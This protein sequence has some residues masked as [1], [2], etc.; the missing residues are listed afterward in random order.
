[1]AP[2][3]EAEGLVIR[4]KQMAAVGAEF[5]LLLFAIARDG[6]GEI[7]FRAPFFF[8][9]GLVETDE[10]AVVGAVAV[11]AVE[12]AV[13]VEGGHEMGGEFVVFPELFEVEFFVLA[14]GELEQRAAFAV[15]FGDVDFVID[16][17]GGGGI[18]GSG[19]FA[20]PR[21]GEVDRGISGIDAKETAGC[22]A[23]FAAC[24]DEDAAL[25]LDGGG[26]W[27]GVRG[28]PVFG[29]GSGASGFAG[30]DI[31]GHDT[32]VLC[33]DVDD[34]VVLFQ[35]GRGTYSEEIGGEI[36]IFEDVAFPEELSGF[37]VQGVEFSFCA[38]GENEGVLFVDDGRTARAVGVA[39]TVLIFGGIAEA[40][41]ALTCFGMEAIDDFFV[42][43]TVEE[44]EAVAEDCGGGIARALFSF[45][46]D[47]QI[48]KV[49][50]KV[51]FSGEGR[52]GKSHEAG[53]I[54]GDGV[55]V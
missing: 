23:R 4:A 14:D 8:A 30:F 20:A 29:G 6:F 7:G 9:G 35:E 42:F 25:A 5:G 26:D 41:I 52:M 3:S 43:E 45:P 10:G 44:D 40:P 18:D 22:G 27:R 54:H 33:A 37:E 21:E 47:G 16:D 28:A 2:F 39:V 55:F 34:Q 13:N 11:C 38:H 19:A 15:A 24:E 51:G 53:G 1:M 17:D 32:G 48:F 46:D 31:E 50:A 49:G 12:I 36:E